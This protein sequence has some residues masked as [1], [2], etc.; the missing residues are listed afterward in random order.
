MNEN[1]V[2]PCFRIFRA[3]D[4]PYITDFFDPRMADFRIVLWGKFRYDLAEIR[5]VEL[6]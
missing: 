1:H 5:S 3:S 2:R 6:G 4:T